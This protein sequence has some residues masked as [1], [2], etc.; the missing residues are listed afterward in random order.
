MENFVYLDGFAQ[1]IIALYYDNEIQ[2]RTPGCYILLNNKKEQSYIYLF[3]ALII[4]ITLE[5]TQEL[6]LVSYSKDFEP[7][8]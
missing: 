3:K 8:V 6:S 4:I 5:G 1:L 2:K 7:E